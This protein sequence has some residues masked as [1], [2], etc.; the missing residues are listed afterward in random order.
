MQSE[1]ISIVVKYFFIII[2]YYFIFLLFR[3]NCPEYGFLLHVRQAKSKAQKPGKHKLK[4]NYRHE[5]RRK[6]KHK[7]ELKHNYKLKHKHDY[8]CTHIAL[9]FA[10]AFMDGLFQWEISF[11]QI[12]Q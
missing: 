8:N 4:H 5:Q 11:Q 3:L 7:H 10:L 6:H 9:L 12:T 1:V 2:K